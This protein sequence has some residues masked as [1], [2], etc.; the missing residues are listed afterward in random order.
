MGYYCYQHA[1]LR[2]H[3]ELVVPYFP[4]RN[5]V[6]RTTRAHLCRRGWNTAAPPVE[7]TQ[8][9]EDISGGRRRHGWMRLGIPRSAAARCRGPAGLREQVHDETASLEVAIAAHG[10]GVLQDLKVHHVRLVLDGLGPQCHVHG[11]LERLNRPALVRMRE[12]RLLKRNLLLH[13]WN[14][15]V[16]VEQ[17]ICRNPPR[18]QLSC[19]AC[20]SASQ[21][22]GCSSPS[23]SS[24]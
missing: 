21:T 2:G 17:V 10:G 22:I 13:L 16:I 23:S 5:A 8:R 6:C 20:C 11:S 1:E 18:P 24:S 9:A 15:L 19:L 4:Q 3:E 14:H 12:V 7:S